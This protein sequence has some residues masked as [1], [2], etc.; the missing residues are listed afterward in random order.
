MIRSSLTIH[1]SLL[2]SYSY[3]YLSCCICVLPSL[4]LLAQLDISLIVCSSTESKLML[5]FVDIYSSNQMDVQN[6]KW[7]I[8]WGQIH[9]WK[10][11]SILYFFGRLLQAATISMVF[12]NWNVGEM[13]PQSFYHWLILLF[14]AE[15][16][17]LDVI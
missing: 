1:I 16:A 8:I 17:D 9:L 2:S 7:T 11:S 12:L 15:W 3:S 10:D 14:L 13:K 6:L 4:T 5:H